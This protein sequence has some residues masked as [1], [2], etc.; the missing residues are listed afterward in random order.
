MSEFEFIAVFVSIIFGLSLTQILSGAIY[1]AQRRELSASHA[2]WTLFVLYMLVINWWTFFPWSQIEQWSFDL[3]FMILVWALAHYVMA[4]SLF[5]GRSLEGYRFDE[6]RRAI[7]WAFIFAALTDIGQ[8]AM[9]GALFSP[10][11]YLVFVN[12]LMFTAAGGLLTTNNRFHRIIPWVL[13]LSMVTWSFV[14]RRF[15]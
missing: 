14:V 9:R 15:L 10:W 2:G 8:T 6:R 13:F 5:P 11:Y 4:T 12:Y 7:C 3:F 1:L